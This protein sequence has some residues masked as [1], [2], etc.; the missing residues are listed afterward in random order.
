[1]NKKGLIAFNELIWVIRIIIVITV[2]IMV[3]AVYFYVVKI[4]FSTEGEEMDIFAYRLLYGPTGVSVYDPLSNRVYPGVVDTERFRK[5]EWAA[6]IDFGKDY[7]AAE[8][9]LF[10][11][12]NTPVATA[13]YSE[14]LYKLWEPLAGVKGDG[15]I[16]ELKKN[17]PVLVE[18]GALDVLRAEYELAMVSNPATQKRLEEVSA[19]KDK[20]KALV[21]AMLAF[22]VV[23]PK[24]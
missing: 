8:I 12:G 2:F 13:Y 14:R 19:T 1:M 11:Q 6:S 24:K 23:T 17:V 21:P 9:I 15:G 22:R 10:D 3:T 16:L 18:E 7:M 20:R 5:G 4:T